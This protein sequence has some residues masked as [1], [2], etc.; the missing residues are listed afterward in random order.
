MYI[1]FLFIGGINV[2]DHYNPYEDESLR[3]TKPEKPLEPIERRKGFNDVMDYF[4]II[5]GYQ[6]PKK[7]DSFPK[8]YR[9]L[10]RYAIIAYLAFSL[11]QLLAYLISILSS[12]IT[13][14]I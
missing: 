4:D 11:C 9:K 13:G 3:L 12:I 10:F 1:E 5:N 7:L 14:Q 2:S 8:K 6:V